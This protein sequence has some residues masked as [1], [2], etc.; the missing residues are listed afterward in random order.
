MC[1]PTIPMG[2]AT[3]T[4]AIASAETMAK[5]DHKTVSP[6]DYR[7]ADV[8]RLMSYA[9][10]E[11]DAILRDRYGREMDGTDAQRLI[12]LSERH[13][14][15]RHIV[16]SPE[17]AD[18][19]D[20]DQLE[21]ATKRTLR[22]VLGE[23]DGVDWAYAVHMDGGDRPHAHVV[24]T[25]KADRRGD[26][27]WMDR[28]DLKRLSDRAHERAREQE[29]ERQ[30]ERDRDQERRRARRERERDRDCVRDRDREYDPW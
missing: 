15:S 18:R 29:R 16:I 17:N 4:N 2:P 1:R 7:R 10:R 13:Q 25:G 8:S 11:R 19:L 23:R 30:L 3:S 12:D 22:D 9:E 14:M 6:T 28:E 27:L 24:A 26:P 5:F 20:R 21:R